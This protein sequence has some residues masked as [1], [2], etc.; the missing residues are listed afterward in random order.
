MNLEN[1]MMKKTSN[2]ITIAV[3]ASLFFPFVISAQV[4]TSTFDV[5]GF[6]DRTDNYSVKIMQRFTEREKRLEERAAERL[7]NLNNR[8]TERNDKLFKNRQESEKRLIEHFAELETRAETF[9]EKQALVKFKSS[10][11]MAIATRKSAVDSAI[12]AFRSGVDQAITERKFAIDSAKVSFK[13][14]TQAAF[15]KAKADCGN[16]VAPVTIRETLAQNLRVAREK[17]EAD[18]K[19]IEKMQENIQSLIST[20]K[21]AV[22]K[23]TSDFKTAMEKAKEDLKI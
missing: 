20:R 2:K 9:E 8:R 6:C 17:F 10:V 1:L 19:A 12:Q 13:N 18:R 7:N 15:D 3:L 21:T 23:A 11:E 5:K 22:E 16:R 4:V 14:S